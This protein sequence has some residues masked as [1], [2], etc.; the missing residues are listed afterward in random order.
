VA[1][2]TSA[3]RPPF[4]QARELYAEL[5]EAEN[6]ETAMWHFSQMKPSEQRFIQAHLL[7]L[8]LHGQT[9][10]NLNLRDIR[11]RLAQLESGWQQEEDEEGDEGEVKEGGVPNPMQLEASRTQ[12]E[13]E[14]DEEDEEDEPDGGNARLESEAGLAPQLQAAVGALEEALTYD[15]EGNAA[16][17]REG[18]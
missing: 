17:A 5:F 16:L 10:T 18:E 12:E 14:E 13:E 8:L 7:Y 4:T 9:V 6:L 15:R 3:A 2:G 1:T 11:L